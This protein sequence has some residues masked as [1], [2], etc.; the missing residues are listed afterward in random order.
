VWIAFALCWRR[1][2]WAA[3]AATACAACAA[4]VGRARGR[5]RS[6][7]P[8]MLV[9]IF[10]PVVYQGTSLYLGTAN[11]DF[12]Q[13]LA[14]TRSSRASASAPSIRVGHRLLP[15]PVL[16]H[17]PDPI[18]AK[19]GGVMFSMLLGKVLFSSRARR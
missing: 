5:R 16:R 19:F 4:A 2:A 7:S 10:W 13:S 6:R 11:P 3:V 12:Y 1:V 14:Y 15:R 8:V 9:A 17:V 18:P